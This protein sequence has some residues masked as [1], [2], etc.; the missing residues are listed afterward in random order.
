MCLLTVGAFLPI[1]KQRGRPKSKTTNT[2]ISKSSFLFFF[3]LLLLFLSSL[4]SFFLSLVYCLS[5]SLFVFLFTF[6]FVVPCLQ[7]ILTTKPKKN[8]IPNIK[9]HHHH[10]YHLHS[11]QR[12]LRRPPQNQITQKA[13]HLDI[14]PLHHLLH[15]PPLPSTRYLRKLRMY[16]RLAVQVTI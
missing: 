12:R 13:S 7:L 9:K 5:F 4:F 8:D 16:I 11:H 6:F 2:T 10:Q 1:E 14:L 15:E 3:L